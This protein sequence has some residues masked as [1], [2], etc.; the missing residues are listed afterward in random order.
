MLAKCWQKLPLVLPA[1]TLP[2]GAGVPAPRRRRRTRCLAV[3]QHARDVRDARDADCSRELGGTVLGVDADE[4]GHSSPRPVPAVFKWGAAP[5]S[6]L[7]PGVH[8]FRRRGQ[9]SQFRSDA[10]PPRQAA[11]RPGIPLRGTHRCDK[12]GTPEWKGVLRNVAQVSNPRR[13]WYHFGADAARPANAVP[14]K[15]Q[16]EG[17]APADRGS[18]SLP[19]RW[20]P[21]SIPGT[22]ASVHGPKQRSRTPHASFILVPGPTPQ[23]SL[24]AP[25]HVQHGMESPPHIQDKMEHPALPT[26]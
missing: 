8:G 15:K 17:G 1:F 19:P 21:Y 20:L 24:E 11:G 7:G 4:A 22:A 23:F 12:S 2:N 26:Q 5:A 10:A 18:C 16:R 3:R 13:N 6:R 9:S 14:E 25:P